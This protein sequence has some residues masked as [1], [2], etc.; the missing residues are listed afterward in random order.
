MFSLIRALKD[1]SSV[2]R[3]PKGQWPGRKLHQG[4]HKDVAHSQ[5]RREEPETGSQ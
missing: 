2:T 5:D 4:H 1:K 3:G